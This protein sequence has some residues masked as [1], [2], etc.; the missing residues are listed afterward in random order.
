M[1][2]SKS[3]NPNPNPNPNRRSVLTTATATA[4]LVLTLTLTAPYTASAYEAATDNA[5]TVTKKLASPSAL[6][7]IKQ[8]L[9]KLQRSLPLIENQEYEEIRQLLRISPLNDVRKNAG[10]VLGGLSEQEVV[11]SGLKDLYGEFISGLEG[12]DGQAGLGQR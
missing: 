8:C 6:R 7:S 1:S 11:E 4:T 12:L 2:Q 9:K 5:K 3:I 10:I